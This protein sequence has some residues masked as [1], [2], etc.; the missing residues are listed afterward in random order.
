M[1]ASRLEALIRRGLLLYGVPEFLE[2][3]A[4]PILRK[5]GDE[6]HAGRLTPSQEH[7]A[8]AALNDLIS[9]TMRSVSTPESAPR[10]I[11]A[12]PAGERHGIG[13][14][15]VGAAAAAD[16]W[17]VISLGTDLPAVEIA[18]AAVA[19]AAV[20]VAVSLL[21]VAEPDQVI[22][23]LRSLRARVPAAV[24]I[25]AGGPGALAL[26][27]KLTGSG[28]RIGASLADLREMLRERVARAGG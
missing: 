21:Y 3:V 9:E 27:D 22:G 16:G 2:R 1:D 14:A 26:G 15:L 25:I 20:V 8:S 18:A 24:E 17:R 4:T 6:W 23:E 11:V 28:V 5:V 19:T 13:A 12:T 10:I 7:L